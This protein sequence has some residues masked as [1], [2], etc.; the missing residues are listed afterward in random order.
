MASYP[1]GD[2]LE[3]CYREVVEDTRQLLWDHWS[4]VEAVVRALE[5][6]GTL[7]GAEVVQAIKT[8]AGE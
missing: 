5:Q 2:S 8:E 4:E 7:N 3:A 1:S 6:T